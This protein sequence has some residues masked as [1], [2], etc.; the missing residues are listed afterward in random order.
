MCIDQKRRLVDFLRQN[1]ILFRNE[2]DTILSN[3][4][5]TEAD[6][7]HAGPERFGPARL[8]GSFDLDAEQ[9]GHHRIQGGPG[10]MALRVR[11]KISALR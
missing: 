5:S 3:Q 4:E 11:N 10:V 2:D 7:G 8:V 1:R 6:H 9:E